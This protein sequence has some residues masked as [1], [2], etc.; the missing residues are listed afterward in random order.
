[1][2]PTVGSFAMD[3]GKAINGFFGKI[4]V[5]IF[6][7]IFGQDEG[8]TPNYVGV[9]DC[10]KFARIVSKA[11]SQDQV[12]LING[13]IHGVV[14]WVQKVY[15]PR[16]ETGKSTKT[17]LLSLLQTSEYDTAV[18]M[19]A[20]LQEPRYAEIGLGAF[21]IGAG[22]H[23]TLLQEM[24]LVDPNADK[25][26]DSSYAASV[27]DYARSYAKFAKET[28]DSIWEKR[29]K[30]IG[31]VRV[32]KNNIGIWI[33][34]W[35]D[36]YRS[37]DGGG[38]WSYHFLKDWYESF[39]NESEGKQTAEKARFDY[40]QNLESA[41]SKQLHDPKG[42]ASWWLKLV[43]NPIPQPQHAEKMMFVENSEE[44]FLSPVMKKMND[45]YEKFLVIE[46]MAENDGEFPSMQKMIENDQKYCCNLL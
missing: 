25:P 2:A 13:Q 26:I 38:A 31:G 30:M 1:M 46:K 24:A 28:Y 29:C 18:K 12:D 6:C 32:R 43:A 45:D 23:L 21:V 42:V 17:E 8:K 41:F 39:R 27:K 9:I 5:E 3:L 19:V 11:I 40:V 15:M 22:I 14:T 36:G 35:H 37:D 16:K 20:V 7:K 34:S 44:L 4:G 10:K 33:Y